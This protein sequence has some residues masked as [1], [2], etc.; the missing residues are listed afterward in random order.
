MKNLFKIAIASS[1]MAVGA[2]AIA[3]DSPSAPT[4]MTQAQKKQMW[5]D[6]MAKQKAANA[7]LTQ[8]AMETACKNEMKKNKL[9]KDGN[10]LTT[11]PTTPSQSK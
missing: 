11:A 4:P 2:Q 10:D 6:C 5:D 8:S 1:L 9:Q 7:G 3:D